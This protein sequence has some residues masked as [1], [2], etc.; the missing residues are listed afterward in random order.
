ML[1]ANSAGGQPVQD[2]ELA[3]P[4]ALV[5]DGLARAFGDAAR[6]ADRLRRLPG[7]RIWRAEHYFGA[8]FLGQGGEP[9]AE[10]LGLALS[11]IGQRDVHVT[12]RDVDH[13]QAGRVR[14]VARDIARTLP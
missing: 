12:Q 8:F 11:Q 1:F 9:V 13:R 3:L 2:A 14:R 10:R 5:D 4:E 6:L 7:T